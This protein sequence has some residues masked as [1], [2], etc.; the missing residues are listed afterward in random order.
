MLTPR[1]SDA[2]R[3][4]GRFIAARGYSPS[5]DEIAQALGLR[6]KSGAHRMVCALV[7]RGCLRHLPKGKRGLEVIRHIEPLRCPHCDGEI[8]LRS[9]VNPSRSARDGLSTHAPE[10]AVAGTNSMVSS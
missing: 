5:Y 6:S 8:H 2:L 10:R 7:E 1:Q 3:F 4:I 9:P